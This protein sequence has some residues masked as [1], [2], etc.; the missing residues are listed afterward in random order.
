VRVWSALILIA[1]T[2]SASA[3]PA[4]P[5]VGR[6]VSIDPATLACSGCSNEQDVEWARSF[7]GARQ[8]P[9]LLAWA[10]SSF[11]STNP[12]VARGFEKATSA[13]GILMAFLELGE[14]CDQAWALYRVEGGY[15]RYCD[16]TGILGGHR[17]YLS[18]LDTTGRAVWECRIPTIQTPVF[19]FVVGRWAVFVGGDR[20]GSVLALVDLDSGRLET[21]VQLPKGQGQFAYYNGDYCLPRMDGMAAVLPA[22]E[23][24]VTK[25]REVR[26]LSV[27]VVELALP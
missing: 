2:G 26:L 23:Q 1:V 3:A 10:Q 16:A 9:D 22:C 11:V 4:T 12:T 20:H 14:A 25:P 7:L 19:P 21:N 8:K 13:A 6:V 24:S 27:V 15:L 18:R 5:K 17:H